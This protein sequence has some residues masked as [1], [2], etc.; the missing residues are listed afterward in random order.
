MSSQNWASLKDK[1]PRHMSCALREA[2]LDG[3]GQSMTERPKSMG[4]S[5]G[6]GQLIGPI[7]QV[8]RK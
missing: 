3:Q 5:H 6:L 2:I 4:L 1:I 8:H 7:S